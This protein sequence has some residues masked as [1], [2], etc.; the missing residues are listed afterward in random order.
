MP[1]HRPASQRR[2]TKNRWP[3]VGG[4]APVIFLLTL[5]ALVGAGCRSTTTMLIRTDELTTVSLAPG[6]TN[7]SLGPSRYAH[8]YTLRYKVSAESPSPEDE[9]TS[10]TR[11]LSPPRVV[12]SRPGCLA[13]EYSVLALPRYLRTQNQRD[14]AAVVLPNDPEFQGYDDERLQNTAAV[15]INSEP[16]GARLYAG[17]KLVG[18]APCTLRY[19]I[20]KQRYQA[21]VLRSVPLVAVAEGCL[22][23]QTQFNLKIDPA[24]RY[25]RNRTYRFSQLFLLKRDPGYR[26]PTIVHN[27]GGGGNAGPVDVNEHNKLAARDGVA[28]DASTEPPGSSL[29]ELSTPPPKPAQEQPEELSRG[30][31]SEASAA[32]VELQPQEGLT[33]PDQ[34]PPDVEEVPPAEGP[35]GP[36]FVWIPGYWSWD[37]AM[38]G[39][40]WFG[41]GWRVGPPGR[42]WMRG[43]PGYPRSFWHRRD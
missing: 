10:P 11:P 1:M 27:Q 3:A 12:I 2:R 13:Q 31:G 32:P 21:T 33:A 42:A 22:P 35:E 34:P 37:V 7:A 43:Y 18:V 39:Y 20:A 40:I 30:R 4:L 26:P 41:G 29:E 25:E 28:A 23:S 16:P 14:A 36:Q 19:R 6:T 24:W 8:A 17:G 15:A 38:N 9:T 5:L